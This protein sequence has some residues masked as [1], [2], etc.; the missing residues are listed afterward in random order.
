MLT[1]VVGGLFYA[2]LAG[3]GRRDARSRSTPSPASRLSVGMSLRDAV[4]ALE[5]V[6]TADGLSLHG[7]LDSDQDT[8]SG[9]FTFCDNSPF[10]RVTFRNGRVTG[11]SEQST[12]LPPGGARRVEIQ[13]E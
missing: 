2:A 13:L 8:A 1:V 9:T 3:G 11:V 12:R 5:P 6:R 7:L 4:L 10:I